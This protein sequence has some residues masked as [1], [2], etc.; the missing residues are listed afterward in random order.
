M[1]TTKSFYIPKQIVMEAF[2]KVKEN[3]GAAGVDAVSLKDFEVNLKD[4]LYKIWNRMSSGCYFPPPVKAVEIPKTGGGMRTL[5]VPTVSD[6]IAQMVV[7][8]VLE[9]TIEPC[10]H[11]DSYGY[12]PGKSALDA[13]KIARQRCWGRDW[14]IDLDI[15][16]FFDNLNHDLVMKAVKKHTTCKWVIL[17]IRRWLKAPMQ[18]TDGTLKKRNLGSIQGGVIS[19]LL[20]NLFLHY[21]FD[22]WM[23]R[24]FQ[25]VSFERY[26]DDIV[27]HCVSYEETVHMLERI[28]LRLKECYLEVHP[29]KTKIVYCKDDRREDEFEYI[30]FDFLGYTFRPRK[31][32]AKGKTFTGFNPAVSKKAKKKMHETIRKWRIHLAVNKT[33][34]DIAESINPVVR[35]WMNYYGKFYPS[36]LGIVLCHLNDA[37]TRWV[38]KKYKRMRRHHRKAKFW[39]G[40]IANKEPGLFCH[41]KMI[42]PLTE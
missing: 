26:A 42:K 34:E 29:G 32:V 16:G 41:W 31:V 24:N 2:R 35:G 40:K 28:K 36:I 22:E 20:A 17:Y 15:K 23:K 3:K 10:F 6:R 1:E 13:V 9:P 27:V 38:K 33:L 5:G 7:K 37:I 30:A 18:Q 11:K 19:P 39:L 21:A 14:V 8:M 25:S 12:R 4:N